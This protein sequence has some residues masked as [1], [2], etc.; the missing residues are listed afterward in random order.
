[1]PARARRAAVFLD[2]DGTLVEDVPYNVDPRLLRLTR[3]AREAVRS[4]RG[5]DY[6]LIVVTNQPGVARGI[7][8]EEAVRA[9]RAH[10]LSDPAL[11]LTDVYYCPHDPAGCRPVYA[12]ACGCRKP[13][14]GMLWRACVEHHLDLERSWLVGD[15]L[16]DVEAG[17][18]AGCR[19][20]LLDN[21]HETEWRWSPMRQP[22]YAVA[23]LAQAAALI[24]ADTENAAGAPRGRGASGRRPAVEEAW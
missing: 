15:I 20:I 3:G 2:K 22:H 1:V 16:D 18:R 12:V 23:D 5:R 7:V 14:P 21:G 4:L 6:L 9:L 17:R 19:T 13:Q 10:L 11:G 8:D 24:A